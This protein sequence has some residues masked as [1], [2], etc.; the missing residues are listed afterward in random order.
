MMPDLS[1]ARL[2]TEHYTDLMQQ[3]TALSV[4]NGMKTMSAAIPDS[5]WIEFAKGQALPLGTNSRILFSRF[6]VATRE[7]RCPSCDSIVYSRRT[8]R[9]GVCEQVLPSNCL[10]TS[11]EAEKVDSL[12]RTE[13]QRHKAWLTRIEAGPC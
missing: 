13:R 1:L 9:C 3:F 10:F 5:R 12:L 6:G 7:R 8:S 2:G 4:V 11:A